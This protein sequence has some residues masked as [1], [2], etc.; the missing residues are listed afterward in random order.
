MQV[1]TIPGPA[2]CF[3]QRVVAREMNPL[4]SHDRPAAYV[5]EGMGGVGKTQLAAAFAREA[6]VAGQLDLLLWIN[7][8]DRIGIESAYTE[9]AVQLSGSNTK[10][11]RSAAQSFLAWLQ[12]IA[13]QHLWRWLIVLDDVVNPDDVHQLWPPASPHGCTVITTRRRDAALS[14]DSRHHIQVGMFDEKEAVSYLAKSLEKHRRSEPPG[15]L[16]ALAQSLGRLPLA[17]SQAAAYMVDSGS[18]AVEYRNRLVGKEHSLADVAPDSLPDD[19]EFAVATTWALSVQKANEL[20][21]KRLA[22]PMLHLTS[23]LDANGIPAAVLTSPPALAYLA[24]QSRDRG[25]H[26]PQ[27]QQ[28][29]CDAVNAKGALRALHRLSLIDHTSEDPYTSVRVHQILQRAVRDALQPARTDQLVRAAADALTAAWPQIERD[30]VL[31]Q[32]LRANASSLISY[33]GD[34]LCRNR[35]HPVLFRIG[36]SLGKSGQVSAA[37]DYF[38]S[39]IKALLEQFP[40]RHRDVLAARGCH[41]RWLGEAGSPRS[42]AELTADLLVDLRHVLGSDDEETLAARSRLA[43][44]RGEAGNPQDAAAATTALVEDLKRIHGW[45]HPRT[46]AARSNLTYWKGRTGD[47]AA[48]VIEAEDL[49]NSMTQALEPD[50]P[51]LFAAR[52][53]LA[54]LRGMAEAPHAALAAL[55]ALLADRKRVLGDHHP[56]TLATRQELAHWQ[57]K[58]GALPQTVS[59]LTQLLMDQERICG[60]N[61]P[62]SLATRNNLACWRHTAGDHYT[63]MRMMEQLVDDMLRALG[64]DHPYTRIAQS[65]MQNWRELPNAEYLPIFY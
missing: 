12:S 10:D 49:V 14:G 33:A 8:G 31:A 34:A 9:A 48:A 6:W 38:E 47:Y 15:E 24:Q 40:T 36:R 7:A 1:G 28:P 26:R 62:P 32:A 46:L 37:C 3:Q 17:L 51:Y 58:V 60:P 19:Q 52:S 39:L 63:A 22:E 27:R 43:R 44:W 11:P 59:E 50:H 18:K 23:V 56:D 13:Q 42:A 5:L 29:V 25:K 55:T 61:S 4:P 64:S 45:N 2:R 21:P 53:H 65:N 57:G 35:A 16:A 54:H 20:R 30:T 41:A